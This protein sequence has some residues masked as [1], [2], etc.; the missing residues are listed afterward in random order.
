MSRAKEL[1]GKTASL[2]FH[3]EDDEHDA[4]EA[5]RTGIVPVGSQL[6]LDE[7]R[8]VLLKNQIILVML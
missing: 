6:L 7:G 1:I 2:R 5:Q 3:L 4:Y 8:P